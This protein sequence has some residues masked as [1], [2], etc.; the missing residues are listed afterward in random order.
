MTVSTANVFVETAE[1]SSGLDFDVGFFFLYLVTI[2]THASKNSS[3][4]RIHM[5]EAPRQAAR[6]S[7]NIITDISKLNSILC[8]VN[9]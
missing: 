3:V 7:S 5:N 4:H 8:A 9:F 6:Q 1:V 2:S